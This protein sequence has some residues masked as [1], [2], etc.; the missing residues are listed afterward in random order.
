MPDWGMFERFEI[1]VKDSPKGYCVDIPRLAA[2]ISELVEQATNGAM[3]A[4]DFVP[5]DEPPTFSE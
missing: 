4:T 5:G 3:T 2:E 1:D